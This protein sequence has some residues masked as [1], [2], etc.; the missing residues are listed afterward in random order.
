MDICLIEY[1]L[2]IR[3]SEM[4]GVSPG[5]PGQQGADFFS[6]PFVIS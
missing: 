3:A 6:H 4:V 2:P 5:S 1:T